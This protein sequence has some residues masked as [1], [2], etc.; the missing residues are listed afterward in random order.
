M[1]FSEHMIKKFGAKRWEE[2]KAEVEARK[3]EPKVVITGIDL[4]NHSFANYV[5]TGNSLSKDPI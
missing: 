1:N 3:N 2:M 5:M 4:L